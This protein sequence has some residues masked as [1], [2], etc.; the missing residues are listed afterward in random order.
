MSLLHFI[1]TSIFTKQITDLLSDDS[2]A[3]LQTYLSQHPEAG[4]LIQ[5]TGGVR[6][7]RWAL[8]STGKSSGLRVIYYFLNEHGVIY[9]LSVYAKSE[10]VNISD[11]D[12]QRLKQVIQAIKQV[13]NNG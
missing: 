4:D 9:M 12:K 3:G 13:H 7:V 5:G 8:S 2:Y 11:K 6:K 1:E 10:Q